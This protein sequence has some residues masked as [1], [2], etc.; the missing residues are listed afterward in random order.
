MLR[1]RPYRAADAAQ[2]ASWVRS[3]E[4]MH[5]W[6]ADCYDHFPISGEDINAMYASCDADFF[7]LT[8]FD[9]SGVAGHLAMRFMNPEKSEVRLCF[10]IV[11]S[12]RRGSGCGKEMVQLAVRFAF[13]IV[14]AQRVSLAVF[15]NNEPAYHCYRAA[16][17]R[18]LED[19]RVSYNIKGED[20]ACRIM[21]MDRED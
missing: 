8:A 21:A 18:V 12:A 13:D 20:W 10:V 7:F 9:E 15:E 3:E 19:E 2:V 17:F 1:I 6:S 16:G 11:D 4:A 5:K 14:K